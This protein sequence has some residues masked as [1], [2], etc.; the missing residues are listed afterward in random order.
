MPQVLVS[1]YGELGNVRLLQEYGFALAENPF[2]C[3]IF[4]EAELATAAA[5]VLGQRRADERMAVC[6]A[7]FSGQD[8]VS[9]DEAGSSEGNDP[10]ENDAEEVAAAKQ[11][12]PSPAPV[13]SGTIERV[14]ARHGGA[15][16]SGDDATSSD[17]GDGVELQLFGRGFVGLALACLVYILGASSAAIQDICNV[18][19][20]VAALSDRLRCS[21]PGAHK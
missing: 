7:I 10:V 6:Q 11:Q 21:D 15:A 4:S 8:T 16:V 13:G 19:D 2:H 12:Q 20:A 18:A 14:S 1:R 5:S 9:S 3:L 17:A